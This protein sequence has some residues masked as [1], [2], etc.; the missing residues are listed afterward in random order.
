MPK[1]D[2]IRVEVDGEDGT[3][4]TIEIS[5][6]HY[7]FCVQ[8][9][10]HRLNGTQAYLACY[11]SAKSKPAAAVSAHDLLR[12]PN[13][14]A[15]I[16]DLKKKYILSAEDVLFHLSDIAANASHE[17]F[18]NYGEDGKQFPFYDLS[19]EAARANMHLVKDLKIK[20]ERRVEGSGEDAEEW[21]V[22]EVEIKLLDKHT[23]LRDMG[24]YHK[25]F[26]DRVETSGHVIEIDF[27]DLTPEQIVR[28]HQGVDPS[29][30][31]KELDERKAA[32]QNTDQS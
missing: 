5:Q 21:E 26:V 9:I 25:L 27:N 8:F 19:S 18:L 3:Q 13:I 23:A 24:R 7:D 12:K 22:E 17:P 31:K 10:I 28:L 16:T 20:R 30:I 6:Q 1:Q 2:L 15:V 29:I 14:Q 32:N 4:T 11:P